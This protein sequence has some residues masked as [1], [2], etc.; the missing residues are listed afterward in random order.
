MV[1]LILDTRVAFPCVRQ[2][3]AYYKSRIDTEILLVLSIDL[4]RSAVAEDCF[5][6]NKITCP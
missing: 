1:V 3:T 5:Y 4:I 2:S 6:V